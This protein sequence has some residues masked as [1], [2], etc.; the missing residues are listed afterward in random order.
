MNSTELSSADIAS[1][2]T[3][4][5]SAVFLGIIGV[6]KLI[7]FS[8]RDNGFSCTCDPNSTTPLVPPVSQA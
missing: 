8:C 5:I 7:N 2:C 6:I 3:G 1:I 4:V